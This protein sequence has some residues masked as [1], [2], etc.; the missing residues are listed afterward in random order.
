MRYLDPGGTRGTAAVFFDVMVRMN[1]TDNYNQVRYRTDRK[2]PRRP[3][4]LS[5][6]ETNIR[7]A[8]KSASRLSGGL[9]K[10]GICSCITRMTA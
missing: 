5:M 8:Y 4:V 1:V 2:W 3:V 10:P 9:N 7:E 6:D